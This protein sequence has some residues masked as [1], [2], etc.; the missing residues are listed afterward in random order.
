MRQTLLCAL[1]LLSLT[2]CPRRLFSLYRAVR[3]GLSERAKA[4]LAA[5]PQPISATSTQ[6]ADCTAQPRQLSL[7]LTLQDGRLPSGYLTGADK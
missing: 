3:R 7:Y 6:V 1:S 4:R 5:E 2:D